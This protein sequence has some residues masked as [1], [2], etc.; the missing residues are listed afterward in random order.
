M[1]C[2]SARAGAVAC[3]DGSSSGTRT[4]IDNLRSNDI[5]TGCG[6]SFDAG[7]H[8]YTTA[9][10]TTP[11]DVVANFAIDTH[12]I[13][14]NV[15]PAEG[16]SAACT[17]NP[18]PHGGDASCSAT[19][20]AGYSFAGWS[21]DCSGASC[22][23]ADVDGPRSVTAT[24]TRSIHTVTPSVAAGSGSMSPDA[25]QQVEDGN[26]ISFILTPATGQVIHSVAGTC[27]GSLAGDTFTTAPGHG[28]LHRD[29]AFR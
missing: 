18:V 26:A 16:G 5:V 24:F 15:S 3:C 12:A 9:P 25:A 7:T 28:R 17:P 8:V 20:A 4:A 13:T 1:R 29:R 10:I 6:G 22:E 14:V 11:C 2:Q 23:L 19:P 27:G 21:G